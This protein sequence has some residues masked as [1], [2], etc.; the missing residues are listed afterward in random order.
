MQV[1]TPGSDG[2]LIHI[3]KSGQTLWTIAEAYGVK[4]EDLMNMNYYISP[5]NQEIYIG[6]KVYVPT[7]P[8]T[9]TPTPADDPATSTPLPVK[10]PVATRTPLQPAAGI[11]T[12]TDQQTL[13]PSSE[14]APALSGG[15]TNK[16]IQIIILA[17]LCLGG[18]LV[19]WGLFF[20][21]SR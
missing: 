4:I 8:V 16:I 3:V 15:S 7:L 19:V 18:I 11:Q 21:R 14:A 10:K 1:A 13:Q 2:Y 6:Q 17:A 5:E 12:Q 9:I 20:N